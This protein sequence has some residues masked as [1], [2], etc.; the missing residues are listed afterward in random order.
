M[1]TDP[2][3]KQQPTADG[4]WNDLRDNVKRRL[5]RAIRNTAASIE[6]IAAVR[7]IK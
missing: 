3:T 4:S 5:P 2:H 6:K 7:R 1:P